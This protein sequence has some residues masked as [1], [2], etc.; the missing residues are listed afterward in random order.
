[1]NSDASYARL[2]RAERAAALRALKLSQV[3]LRAYLKQPPDA[4]LSCDLWDVLLAC[5][6]LGRAGARAVCERAHVWP[7]TTLGELL[8]RERLDLVKSIPK[9]AR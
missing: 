8:K 9:R 1:M 5:P 7:H 4:L 2:R 6:H 3:T